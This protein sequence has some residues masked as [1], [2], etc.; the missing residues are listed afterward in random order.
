MLEWLGLFAKVITALAL[1][2]GLRWLVL[3]SKQT[4]RSKDG[5]QWLEYG[6]GLKVLALI[7]LIFPIIPLFQWWA[8]DDGKGLPFFI[9]FVVFSMAGTSLFIEGFL[10]RVGFDETYLYCRSG[11]RP[12][13]QIPWDQIQGISFSSLMQWWLLD[14]KKSGK[15]RLHVYLIGI[16]ALFEKAMAMGIPINRDGVI[17]VK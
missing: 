12:R 9:A 7:A 6:W 2:A 15:V 14:T 11:W 8:T 1:S 16:P 5:V 4:T 13:R 10:V 17:G 3:S